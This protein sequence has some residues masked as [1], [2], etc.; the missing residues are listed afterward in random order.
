[1]G[2]NCLWIVLVDLLEFSAFV[3]KTPADL[4]RVA[5]VG[6][7]RCALTCR[8]FLNPV[9]HPHNLGSI[10]ALLDQ[11]ESPVVQIVA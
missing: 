5:H 10:H 7:A 3:H 4:E 1:M 9:A 11:A 2:L 6:H 8:L